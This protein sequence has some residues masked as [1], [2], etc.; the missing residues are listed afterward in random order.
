MIDRSMSIH[1]VNSVRTAILNRMRRRNKKQG[2]SEI[3]ES[4]GEQQ[5]DEGADE[6]NR[7]TRLG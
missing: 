5:T 2:Y 3:N 1:S 7:R 4:A 6:I